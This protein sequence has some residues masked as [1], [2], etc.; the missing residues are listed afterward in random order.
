MRLG[1]RQKS[2]TILPTKVG[3]RAFLPLLLVQLSLTLIVIADVALR[4]TNSPDW[5]GSFH[6]DILYVYSAA[7]LLSLYG[8]YRTDRNYWLHAAQIALLL[9]LTIG[10]VRQHSKY[11]PPAGEGRIT[12][13]ALLYL[14]Y[15]AYP[16]LG[17]DLPQYLRDRAV[18]VTAYATVLGI[19][20]IHLSG[21]MVAGSSQAAYVVYVALIFGMNLFFIPRY[22]SRDVFFWS[23]GLTSALAVVV[24][25][26]AYVVGDY[27]L[28]WF[29]IQ[30][31]P[32]TFTMPLIGIELHFLQSIFANP[33]TLGGLTFGGAFASLV[34]LSEFLQRRSFRLIRITAAM[35]VVN[36]I[37]MYAS[38][39][40]ASWL[41]FALAASV[42]LI[43]VG[44]GRRIAAYTIVALGVLTMLFFVGMF[45]HVVPIDT[46]GRF[47]LWEGGLRAIQHAP[48]PLGYSIV[49]EDNLIAP[50]VPDPKYRGFSPHNS[51]VVMFIHIGIIGGLAYLV[52]M[53]GSIVEGVVRYEN[54]DLPMLA[55]AVGF[56]VHHMFE[57]YTMF[58][59]AIASIVSALVFGYLI[60]GHRK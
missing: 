46:H 34:L 57:A 48:G 4:A 6:L 43:Y 7:G 45:L 37:G 39:S 15:L 54:V 8:Y 60:N 29:Q 16:L 11:I 36:C 59:V 22:V 13:V 21:E 53:F 26:P 18:Y 25:L 35:L 3:Q 31:F 30:L 20:F 44:F 55:F 50:F 49:P 23:V 9:I 17:Y 42:Y 19:Y 47:A 33:N 51:Y 10:L 58:N 24:G 27:Q 38:Y 56:S 28:S 5:Y 32:T 2:S 1:E 52:L 14:F 12:Y 40:R 41:A